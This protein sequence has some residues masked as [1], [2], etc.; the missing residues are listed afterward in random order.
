VLRLGDLLAETELGL[1]LRTG[2]P[3]AAERPLQGA[4]VV[5]VPEPSLAVYVGVT[6]ATQPRPVSTG[7]RVTA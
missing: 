2:P 4:A 6:L 1:T 7:A 5:E 3:E